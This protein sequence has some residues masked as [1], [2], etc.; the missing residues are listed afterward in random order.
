MVNLSVLG[1][2]DAG[3]AAL[4]NTSVASVPGAVTFSGNGT[5]AAQNPPVGAFAG[6]QVI[7]SASLVGSASF[8]GGTYT[9]L[10]G[11]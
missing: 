4:I 2:E 7:G 10:A 6:T 1:A 3:E 9:L 5:N 8:D 11:Q